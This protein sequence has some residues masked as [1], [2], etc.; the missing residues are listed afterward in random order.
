MM[1]EVAMTMVVMKTREMALMVV[2]AVRVT[3]V[4]GGGWHLW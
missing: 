2:V 1:V 3:T 4:M